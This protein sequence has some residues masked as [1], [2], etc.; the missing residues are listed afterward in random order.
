M[1]TFTK[2]VIKRRIHT[3]QG[4]Y[5]ISEASVGHGGEDTAQ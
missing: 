5:Y 2:V 1:V 4:S 3:T